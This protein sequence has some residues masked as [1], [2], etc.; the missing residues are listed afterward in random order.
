MDYKQMT[1][2]GDMFAGSGWCWEPGRGEGRCHGS[3]KH[4]GL[5]ATVA[6]QALRVVFPWSGLS[7]TAVENLCQVGGIWVCKKIQVSSQVSFFLTLGSLCFEVVVCRL[8]GFV[9]FQVS[10]VRGILT[11]ER[12]QSVFE[13]MA[14][15]ACLN[16]TAHQVLGLD[17]FSFLWVVFQG[18]WTSG[19]FGQSDVGLHWVHLSLFVLTAHFDRGELCAVCVLLFFWGVR[20]GVAVS[21][22][23]AGLA[24][25]CFSSH[26]KVSLVLFLFSQQG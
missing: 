26:S 5:P 1:L 6:G 8:P 7:G 14:Q 19:N 12:A 3:D 10:D 9:R 13:D 15:F 18:P 2:R 11:E 22:F 4:R 25:C 23:T 16:H 20:G 21:V 17:Q 24:L